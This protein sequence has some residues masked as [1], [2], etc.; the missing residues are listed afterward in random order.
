MQSITGHKF[1]ILV[2]PKIHT[3][4]DTKIM[5][6]ESEGIKIEQQRLIFGGRLLDDEK[7]LST[8]SIQENQTIHLIFR[9][10]GGI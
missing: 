10:V 7:S 5:I 2:N 4:R 8:Y 1:H 6:F 3:V 9:I